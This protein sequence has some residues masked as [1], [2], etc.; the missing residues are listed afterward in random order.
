MAQ[1]GVVELLRMDESSGTP[2]EPVSR[3]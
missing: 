1:S 2:L 3:L